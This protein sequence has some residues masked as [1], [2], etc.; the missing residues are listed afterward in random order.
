M[1]NKGKKQLFGGVILFCVFVLFT[2][3]LKFA[4]LKD[5]GVNGETVAYAFINKGVRDF[6]GVNM[7]L[8]HITDWLGVAAIVIAFFFAVLGLIQ[9]IKRKNILKVDSD[10]LILGVF[11]IFVFAFYVF[12]EYTVINHRPIL[13][14]GYLESSYPSSTTLL[15][16]TVMPTARLQFK[17]RIKNTVLKNTVSVICILVTV[18]AVMGRLISG[19]HWFTDILGSI[20]LSSSLVLL[21]CGANN[22]IRK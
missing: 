16:I 7:T 5:I 10:L 18:F 11:Y 4:N 8:Y 21:Y 3:S 13:I 1:E 20:L 14:N 12:F 22:M 15:F 2:L 19:V 17:S 9:W 6:F